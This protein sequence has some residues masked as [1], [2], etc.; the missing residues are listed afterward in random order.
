MDTQYFANLRLLLKKKMML[1]ELMIDLKQLESSSGDEDLKKALI[2]K[3]WAEIDLEKIYINQFI[4]QT[5]LA[6]K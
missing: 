1:E 4:K 3:K 5:N 2:T 6:V